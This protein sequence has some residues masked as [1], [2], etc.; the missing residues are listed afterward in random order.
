[1]SAA[2]TLW[3]LPAP[4]ST[5]PEERKFVVD[6]GASMHMLSGKDLIQRNW[7]LFEYPETLQRHYSQRRSAEKRGS[8]SVRQRF[9]FSRYSSYLR[10]YRG[11][12]TAWVTLRRSRIPL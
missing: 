11:S 1:M 6:S 4:S 7:T 3:C 9:G 5:K 2:L 8:N 12:S 10:G